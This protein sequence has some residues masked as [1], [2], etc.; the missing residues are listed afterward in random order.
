MNKRKL[1]DILGNVLEIGLAVITLLH[2]LNEDKEED[3]AKDKD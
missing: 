1:L 2:T 3:D